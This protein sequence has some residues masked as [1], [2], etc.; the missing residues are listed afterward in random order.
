MEQCLHGNYR[1][2]LKCPHLVSEHVGFK[3]CLHFLLMHTLG[4]TG[5]KVVGARLPLWVT[6]T[7][8]LPPGF[9]LY[10]PSLFWRLRN[11]PVN[12]FPFLFFK[13]VKINKDPL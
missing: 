11:E 6:W 2:C 4:G 12:Q 7:E 3:F 9:S 8:F 13:K 1:H 10:Q 5:E